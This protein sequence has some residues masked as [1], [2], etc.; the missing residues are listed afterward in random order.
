MMN[1]NTDPAVLMTHISHLRFMLETGME[2][3]VETFVRRQYDETDWHPERAVLF[4]FHCKDDWVGQLVCWAP[5][6]YIAVLWRVIDFG[7]HRPLDAEG[8][9]LRGYHDSCWRDSLHRVMHENFDDV[10][11]WDFLRMWRI[12]T[13]SS[14]VQE[15]WKGIIRTS[16][17]KPPRR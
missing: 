15:A 1:V 4:Q 10:E 17:E 8:W 13:V 14:E 12:E 5:S 6:N 3:V 9:E 16:R 11:G 2:Q 7:P